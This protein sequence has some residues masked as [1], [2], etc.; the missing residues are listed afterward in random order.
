MSDIIDKRKCSGCTA[1]VNI[2][3]KSAIKMI[4]D[5]NGFKYPKK[6]K[7]KCNNCGLCKRICPVI[8]TK[9]NNSINKCYIALNKNDKIREKSSSG[10]I[11]DLIARSIIKDQGIVIGAAFENKETLVHIA[12]DNIDDLDKLRGSKYVQSD[13]KEIF[14][15]IKENIKTKK[16]L[17]V[18]LPCQ[19]AGL[20]AYLKKEYDNLICIDLFCHGVPSSKLFRKHIKELENKYNDEIINY[21]FRDKSTGWDTYS[22]TV[23]LKNK[24]IT[25]LRQKDNYMNLFLCDI[26]LRDSC[27]NCNFKLGNKYSD[28]TLGDFWGIKESYP[29]MYDKK[30]VSAVILNNQKGI[31]IF[32]KIKKQIN[33]KECKIEEILYGNPSLKKSAHRNL[34]TKQFFIDLNNKDIFAL[35]Q[36][37]VKKPSFIK[38]VIT[39]TKSIIFKGRR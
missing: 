38:K 3:P 2:C 7:Q 12:V 13:L 39:K 30:G 21:N 26:A 14:K 4:E 27:Y 6:D 16:I 1:C 32:H 17:F 10:G 24:K 19:V 23:T 37:Y 8:N 29:N 5:E 25:Q 35:K 20:K 33:Y 11:F 22:T 9:K 34:E 31:E 18:G 36:K 28:I 15:Y